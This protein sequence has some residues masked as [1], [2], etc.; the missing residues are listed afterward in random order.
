MNWLAGIPKDDVEDF[1]WFLVKQVTGVAPGTEAF[2][3]ER[4]CV[5]VSMLGV[6]ERALVLGRE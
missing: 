5:Y 4:K 3:A 6:C 2:K 1:F